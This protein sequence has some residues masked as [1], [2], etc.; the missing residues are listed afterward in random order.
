MKFWRD[1][2]QIMNYTQSDLSPVKKDPSNEVS[3]GGEPRDK[4]RSTQLP[5]PAVA[6]Q[7]VIG[8][9]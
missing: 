6:T 5:S 4:K 3:I 1:T 2:Y 7:W 9:G 8:R